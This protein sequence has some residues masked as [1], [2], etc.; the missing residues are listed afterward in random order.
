M[1]HDFK[2]LLGD[3]L[4]RH[5]MS[6]QV[7]TAQLLEIAGIILVEMLPPTR[8]SDARAVS[9]AHGILNITAGNS[10]A[11]KFLSDR[12]EDIRSRIVARVPNAHIQ[13]VHIKIGSVDV[14]E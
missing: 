2:S 9:F 6:R 3:A 5:Q 7:T 14:L 12:K 4:S 13:D 11:G 10:P 1:F 8:A